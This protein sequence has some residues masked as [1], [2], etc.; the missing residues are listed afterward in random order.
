MK[1]L[2]LLLLVF[3]TLAVCP[4]ISRTNSDANSVLTSAKYNADLNT[5]YSFV[6]AYDLG[7]VTAGAGPVFL[8][9]KLGCNL[10][11]SSASTF[12]VSPC[13]IAVSG[14]ISEASASTSWAWGETGDSASAASTWFYIYADNSTTFNLIVS[15][16]T[17]DTLGYSGSERVIGRFKTDTSASGINQNSLSEYNGHD[18]T[19][20]VV[21][22]SGY[23]TSATGLDSNKGF[24]GGCFSDTNVVSAGI[25]SATFDSNIFVPAS[26]KAAPTCQLTAAFSSHG[27]TFM[28]N[29]SENAGKYIANIKTLSDE[30]T[31]SNLGFYYF[32]SGLR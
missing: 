21:T 30:T 28:S 26:Y 13:K 20:N 14:I 18:Y 15:S 32:C 9:E 1:I 17:P 11:Q 24:G 4:S 25:Y 6:N 31:Y 23:Y 7:C 22:C 10:T 29:L 19:G 2:L 12:Y 27:F 8:S 16:S 3:E 5:V